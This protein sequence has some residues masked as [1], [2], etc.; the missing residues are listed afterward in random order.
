[1]TTSPAPSPRPTTVSALEALE[2]SAIDELYRPFLQAK[3]EAG[4]Q[5]WVNELELDTVTEMAARNPRK[6][7]VLILYGSLRAR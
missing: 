3:N 5:D 7:K 1:M 2:S 4:E 6:V